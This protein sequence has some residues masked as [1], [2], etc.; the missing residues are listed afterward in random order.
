MVIFISNVLSEWSRFM[1]GFSH[2]YQWIMI[3]FPLKIQ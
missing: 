1:Y 2:C 3:F